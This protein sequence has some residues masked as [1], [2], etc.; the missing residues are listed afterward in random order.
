[1]TSSRTKTIA[2]CCFGANRRLV[3]E[4]RTCDFCSTSYEEHLQCKREA[5]RR[6]RERARECM[7]G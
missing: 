2:G 7:I 4:V 6:S 1:M 5:E 3:E